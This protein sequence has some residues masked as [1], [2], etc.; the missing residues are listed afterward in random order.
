MVA[1]GNNVY[2]SRGEANLQQNRTSESLLSV[3]TDIG[4][5]FRPL[6]ML[7]V[8]MELKYKQRYRYCYYYPRKGGTGNC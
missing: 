6:V 3:S 5:T 2:V 1:S 8:L 7:W 4:Q